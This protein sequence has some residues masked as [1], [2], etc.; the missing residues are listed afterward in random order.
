MNHMTNNY[1][2]SDKWIR[3][4]QEKECHDRKNCMVKYKDKSYWNYHL[5]YNDIEQTIDVHQAK[6]EFQM[7]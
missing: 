5:D 1:H 4:E 2:Y 3:S 7:I 6:I